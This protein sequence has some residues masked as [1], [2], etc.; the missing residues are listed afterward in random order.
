MK[1]SNGI[2]IDIVIPVY[3]EEKVLNKNISIL[4][5][6][7]AKYVKYKCDI[8]IAD[9]GSTDNTWREVKALVRKNQNVRYV[10]LPKKGRGGALKKIWLKSKADVLCYLDADLS[11]DLRALP[12]L[13]DAI[14]EDGFHVAVGSRLLPGSKVKRGLLRE[15]ISRGYNAAL[16]LLFGGRQFSDAQC[17]FKALRRNVAYELVPLIKNENWFFDTELLVLAERKGLRIKDIPV[18]WVER[19]E[20]KVMILKTIHEDI[21]GILR[22]LFKPAAREKF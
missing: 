19:P 4:Q 14:V 10:Y 17:G 5:A 7:L 1:K 3:N 13:F 22:L 2:E 9:N 20:S 15:V 6:F 21:L 11:T 18:L 16:R 12:E 8:I